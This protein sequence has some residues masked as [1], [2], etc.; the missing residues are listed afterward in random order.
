MMQADLTKVRQIL[1]N[2]L[3]NA[4]KFTENGVITLTVRKQTDKVTK[5]HDDRGVKPP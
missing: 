2:L 1:F 3:S 5:E 4:S